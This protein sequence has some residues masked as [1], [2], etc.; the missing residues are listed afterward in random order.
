MITGLESRI[1]ILEYLFV[2]YNLTLFSLLCGENDYTDM[3][4]RVYC[5]KCLVL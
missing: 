1:K 5:I 4:K 3:K 2:K